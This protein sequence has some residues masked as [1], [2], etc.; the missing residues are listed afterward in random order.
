MRKKKIVYLNVEDVE[1]FTPEENVYTKLVIKG[2]PEQFKVFRR[3]QNFKDLQKLGLAISF[4]PVGPTQTPATRNT[5]KKGIMEIL[6]DLIKGDNQYIKDAFE[7][8]NNG[9]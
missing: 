6:Q 5:N 9:E 1:G 2:T 8:L 3:G 4:S 7:E